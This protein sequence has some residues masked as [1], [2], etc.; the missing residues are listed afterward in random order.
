MCQHVLLVASLLL[1]TGMGLW[2]TVAFS[3]G[4]PDTACDSM[5]PGHGSP[6]QSSDTPFFITADKTE[7]SSGDKVQVI[8]S[9]PNG[10]PFKGFLIQARDTNT[11]KILGT[12]SSKE[13]KFLTCGQGFNNAVTHMNSQVEY[14]VKVNWE[15]PKDY[16]GSVIFKGTFLA[17]FTVFWVNVTSE[18]LSITKR[19]VSTTTLAPTPAPTS[20]PSTTVG[21]T[22]TLRA[23]VANETAK[24][25]TEGS[26][27]SQDP[28]TVGEEVINVVEPPNNVTDVKP[29]ET[30]T[31]SNSTSEGAPSPDSDSSNDITTASPAPKPTPT[32]KPKP[33]RK[34]PGKRRFG[35]SGLIR[36]TPRSVEDSGKTTTPATTT[37]SEL[38]PVFSNN[39]TGDRLLAAMNTVYLGCG[40]SKGCFGLPD[41]CEEKDRCN[42][43]VT[44]SKVSDGFAFE[45]FGK[46][47][48]YMAFGLSFDTLMGDDSVVVCRNLDGHPDVVMTWNSG[49]GNSILV[50]AQY[51]L[52]DPQA[53]AIDGHIY[54]RFVREAQTETYGKIFDLDKSRFHIMM[55]KGELGFN[56]YLTHHDTRTVSRSTA[57]L[58]EFENLTASSDLFKLLHGC[59]MLAA[60]MALVPLATLLARYYKTTW[61][62]HNSCG[63]AQWFHWHR[64][65][66]I[67]AW[68]LT[69]VGVG[70]I[71]YFF[72]GEWRPTVHSFL[73]CFV[74]G[75]AFLQPFIAM[76]RCSP[77]SKNRPFFNWIH[78]F[79]GQSAL[80]ISMAAIFYGLEAY[81]TKTWVYWMLIL[82]IAF[83]CLTHIILSVA[84]CAS[85]ASSGSKQT[86]IFPLKDL[87]TLTP[88]HHNPDKASDAPGSAFRRA[89]LALYI[90]VVFSIA[91]IVIAA[92]VLEE[93]LLEEVGLI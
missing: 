15:A 17:N 31:P 53:A 77:D 23:V 81:G 21:T 61:V 79:I 19:E 76:L 46:S 48:G 35:I 28:A 56:G 50:N 18:K 70:F 58:A 91:A 3:I 69:L 82:F 27:G 13:Y 39:A 34:G 73:G 49:R 40:F 57:S 78:W 29:E 59:L 33:K 90:L 30:S 55:A 45:L 60:W 8:M 85:D 1:L 51:G 86:N 24:V 2:P 75:L 5:V 38:P 11:D 93:D 52:R 63:I 22:T 71:F 68:S 88:A 4:A 89:L 25:D 84:Q 67:L 92:T 80:I 9:S 44:Y 72:K 37:T 26:A 41:G 66:A 20:S 47:T 12:F 16:T 32:P 62:N 65:L 6:P 10:D 7:V 54:C 42:M 14:D 74:T 87:H 64:G 83:H 43:L 36:T